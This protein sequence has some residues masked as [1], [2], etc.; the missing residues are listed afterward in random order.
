MWVKV[1]DRLPESS[2]KYKVIRR[3]IG[4]RPDYEDECSL[5]R[6][7]DTVSGY[8]HWLNRQGKVITTV[9]KWWEED[10]A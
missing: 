1:R 10:E 2:G 7:M 5:I 9:V 4:N 8:A 3:A 6:S